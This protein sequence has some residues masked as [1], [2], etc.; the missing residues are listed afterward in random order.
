VIPSPTASTSTFPEGTA[1]D[2]SNLS[3][4]QAENTVSLEIQ[5]ITVAVFLEKEQLFRRSIADALNKG[6]D[7]TQKKRQKEEFTADDI[8][9]VGQPVATDGGGVVVAFFTEYPDGQRV[10]DGSDLA[11]V[12]DDNSDDIS[13]A[14]GGKVRGIKKG[15]PE[16]L[17]PDGDGTDSTGS[18]GD[19]GGLSG[20]AVAAIVVVVLIVAVLVAMAV[21][22]AVLVWFRKNRQSFMIVTG[23]SATSDPSGDGGRGGKSGRVFPM[24]AGSDTYVPVP[25]TAMA[26]NRGEVDDQA[27]GKCE[28]E[29]TERDPLEEGLKITHL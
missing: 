23:G 18:S 21:A 16:A 11:K 4:E 26:A 17:R 9:Y 25:A 15:V 13:D 8:T 7:L 5:G 22:G 24:R 1:V 27:R 29:A 28:D 10:V 2:V 3:K 6:I 20:A 14:A 19:G 12:L